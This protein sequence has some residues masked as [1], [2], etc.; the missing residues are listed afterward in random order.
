MIHIDI[1]PTQIQEI[2]NIGQWEFLSINDEELIDTVSRGFFSDSELVRIY[3]GTV[4]LGVDLR[5]AGPQ[6]LHVEGDSIM[7]RSHRSHFSSE[8]SLMKHAHGRSLRK[9]HGPMA[10]ENNSTNVLTGR[11]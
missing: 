11:C 8:T 9:E 4:R 3:Y 7:L 6:W 2:Q 5:Q 1:T 10:T